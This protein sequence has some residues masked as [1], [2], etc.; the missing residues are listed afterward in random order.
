MKIILLPGMDGTG[1]LFE[2]F[3]S[4]LA[5]PAIVIPLPQFGSQDYEFLAS[6]VESQLPEDEEFIIVAESFSGPIAVLLAAKEIVNLKRIVF[7]ATFLVC[8]NLF[9]T[10][11]ARLLP[12]K[13]LLAAPFAKI[14]ILRVL[15]DGFSYSQFVGALKKVS[16]KVLK[17]RLRSIY[18]LKTQDSVVNI[19]SL[20][21]NASFDWLVLK[22]Q[23]PLFK[24]LF[25]HIQ[26]EYV[27]GAHCLLQSNPNACAEIINSW[28]Y[29]ARS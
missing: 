25:Q 2:P 8:P 21:L 14:V 29:A 19:P 1:D 27:E 23:I 17:K 13:L 10:F 3:R 9:L 20:Y 28:I 5:I 16:S 24:Q 11:I 15:L 26:I 4:L 12:L 18:N 6:Y 7:V 22:N